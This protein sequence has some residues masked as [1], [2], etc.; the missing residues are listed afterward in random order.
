MESGPPAQ[1]A[2]PE[3][4][5]IGAA[6]INPVEMSLSPLLPNE[7]MQPLRCTGDLHA[8]FVARFLLLIGM[9][10]N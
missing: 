1:Q 6:S 4:H 8:G 2:Q 9:V 10:L 3:P 7:K 5:A